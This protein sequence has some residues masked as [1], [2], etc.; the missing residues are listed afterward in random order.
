MEEDA[1]VLLTA[2]EAMAILR[3]S[4]STLVR[5]IAAGQLTGLKVGRCWR[6]WRGDLA[7]CVR[8]ATGPDVRTPPPGRRKND[9]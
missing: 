3:V 2:R 5:L 7:A 1:D 4:R 9:V 6:F 8:Q